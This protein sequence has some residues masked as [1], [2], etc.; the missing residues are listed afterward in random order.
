MRRTVMLIA[1]VAFACQEDTDEAPPPDAGRTLADAAPPRIE[2]AAPPRMDVAP[3]VDVAPPDADLVGLD[4]GGERGRQGGGREDRPG[5]GL[6]RTES[7]AHCS[8]R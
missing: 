1:L 2:D 7:H 6:E 4:V 5:D 8:L 3:A